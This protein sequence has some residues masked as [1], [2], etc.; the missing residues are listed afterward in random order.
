VLNKCEYPIN[1]KMIKLGDIADFKNGLNY[2]SGENKFS[3]HILS[4]A[5]FQ[6][7]GVIRNPRNLPKVDLD[8]PLEDG[9][10]LVDR[11]LV[12]VRSNGNPDLVGRCVMVFPGNVPTTFSGFTIRARIVKNKIVD[13]EWVH[14]CL[15]AGLLKK[16]LKR[17][18]AGTNITNLN[19]QILSSVLIPIPSM[20]EQKAIAAILSTWDEA[21]EKTERLIELKEIS[22]QKLLA[23]KVFNRNFKIKNLGKV[24]REVS[25][26]NQTGISRVLSVTNHSG[27]ILPEDQFAR[28][29]ASQNLDNYKVVSK[30]QYA[31]NPSRINVGSIARLDQWDIGVLSP[32]Y[33]V[34]K[35]DETVLHSD[36]LYYWLQTKEARKRIC[37]STQGSVRESV[38]FSDFANLT[39]PLPELKVQQEIICQ[40]SLI[41]EELN[42]LKKTKEKILLQKQGL[43]QKLLTG[44]WRVNFKEEK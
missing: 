30:G 20:E 3:Y 40:L 23:L 5:S 9:F 43:M 41:E 28:R 33:V 38:S 7:H 18:G 35:I 13:S 12:F 21:I 8:H 34:F 22:F 1:W 2:R 4:V 14:I 39:I 31:Y 24:I 16:S 10:Q 26:R 15:K 25:Q 27:F 29:V 44:K 17:E 42:N 11:D 19:Q 36:F 37:A 6:D 32:M